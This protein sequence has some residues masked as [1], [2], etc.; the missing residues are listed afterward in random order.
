MKDIFTDK[1][2]QF[3]LHQGPSDS[4]SVYSIGS[5]EA[6]TLPRSGGP[7]FNRKKDSDM[8]IQYCYIPRLSLN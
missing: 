6:K 8:Y 5:V 1:I 7:K 4:D 2:L 3:Y